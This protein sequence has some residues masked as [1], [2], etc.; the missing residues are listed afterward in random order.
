LKWMNV[1]LTEKNLPVRIRLVNG[2]MV[3]HRHHIY[4]MLGHTDVT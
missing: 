3:I 1:F 4:A 2:S